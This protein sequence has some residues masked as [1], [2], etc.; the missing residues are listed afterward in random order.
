MISLI[1]RGYRWLDESIEYWFQFILYVYLTAII[2]IEVIRRYFFNASSSWGEETALY[3]FVWMSY[4]ATARGVKR[5][6]HLS[7]DI[8]RVRMNRTQLFLSFMLSDV[9]FMTLAIVIIFYAFPMVAINL[10][11]DQRMLGVDLPLVLA[12]GAIPV[13]WGLIALRVLQRMIITI[14]AFLRG[15]PIKIGTE[16]SE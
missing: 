5:R 7:L 4:I 15:E 13:A 3:A 2:V 1:I 8:L 6:G 9:C 12:T 14:C 16:I 11:L 10:R